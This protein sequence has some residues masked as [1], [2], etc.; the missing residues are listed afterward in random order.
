MKTITLE[1]GTKVQISDESY[2]AL[3]KAVQ[4]PVW[5]DVVRKRMLSGLAMDFFY[6]CGSD[7]YS[8]LNNE[9]SQ[10]EF[11]I[12]LHMLLWKE[13]YDKDFVPDWEDDNQQDKWYVSYSNHHKRWVIDYNYLERR[14]MQV[15][16][17]TRE[18]AEQ[19]IEDLK[20]IGVL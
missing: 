6:D 8:W 4:K 9:Q 17:S 14:N 18:K 5:K 11:E 3:Q 16:V 12:Y 1:N 19:M 2:Q 15:Y 7:K 13:T 20:S 10:K